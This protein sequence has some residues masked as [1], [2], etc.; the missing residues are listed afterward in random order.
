MSFV[1]FSE[2]ITLVHVIDQC[3]SLYIS[4]NNHCLVFWTVDTAFPC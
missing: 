4:E 1:L 3:R 2:T